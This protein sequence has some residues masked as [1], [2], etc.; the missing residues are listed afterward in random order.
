MTLRPACGSVA[1]TN[2]ENADRVLVWSRRASQGATARTLLLRRAMD[3]E[4]EWRRGLLIR[5]PHDSSASAGK[6][7]TRHT[8]VNEAMLTKRGRDIQLQGDHSFSNLLVLACPLDT[9]VGAL[10][11]LALED[12]CCM[13]A[14]SAVAVGHSSA[15][16]SKRDVHVDHSVRCTPSRAS[17]TRRGAVPE[18]P[19]PL[20]D[21]AN[22]GTHKQTQDRTNQFFIDTRCCCGS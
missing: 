22:L 7:K 16:K 11:D 18:T 21:M 2:D 20:P 6:H 3:M 19:P 5:T 9:M 4:D 14:S 12:L 17:T 13:T 15:M 8:T 1:G 10:P